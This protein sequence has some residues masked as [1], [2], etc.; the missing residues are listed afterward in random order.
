MILDTTQENDFVLDPF[1]GS[2]TSAFAAKK[3]NRNFIGFE[4]NDKYFD[5]IQERKNTLFIDI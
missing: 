4:L 1:C 5:V 3:L 2:G